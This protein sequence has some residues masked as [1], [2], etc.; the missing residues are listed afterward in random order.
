MRITREGIIK[1]T[2]AGLTGNL[3]RLHR[4][5]RE[6]VTGRKLQKPSDEPLSAGSIL[7]IESRLRLT[8]RYRRAAA[9]GGTRMSTEEAVL[10]SAEE[11]SRQAHDLA[12]DVAASPTEENRKRALENIRSLKEQ[13]IA[14]GNTRIGGEYVFG[15]T[16]SDVPPFAPDGTYQGNTDVRETEVGEGIRIP[17]NHAGSVILSPAL[18]AFD[19]LETAIQSG[20]SDDIEAAIRGVNDARDVVRRAQG[21]LSS[22]RRQGL[23]MDRR[24]AQDKASLDGQ[25]SQLLDSD[26]TE[27]LLK[28]NESK[29]ALDRAYAS[30]AQVLNTNLLQFLR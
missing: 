13:L 22:W 19:K 18:A 8:E 2:H 20:S 9:M 26:P 10:N 21:E 7:D 23:E 27:G 16:R 29:T 30:V 12:A 25:E 4:A 14:T 3:D 6:I 5:E 1:S 24:L 28:L 11:V 15:G 17:V